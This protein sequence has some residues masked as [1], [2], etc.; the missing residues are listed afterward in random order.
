VR[1]TDTPKRK[2]L[3]SYG[4]PLDQ[5]TALGVTNKTAT[6]ECGHVVDTTATQRRREWVHCFDCSY[7]K[8]IP[9]YSTI[10]DEELKAFQIEQSDETALERARRATRNS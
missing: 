3:R 1:P 5:R 9:S 8:P 6:L 7:G 2:I 10:T 4:N